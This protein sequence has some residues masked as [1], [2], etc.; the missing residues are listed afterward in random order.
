MDTKIS[1]NK[2]RVHPNRCF[3]ITFLKFNFSVTNNTKNTIDLNCFSGQWPERTYFPAVA[4][5]AKTCFLATVAEKSYTKLG[6]K[7][8]MTQIAVYHPRLRLG[9]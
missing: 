7:K 6:H 4:R 2:L 3:F 1:D 9:R 8:I 5:P